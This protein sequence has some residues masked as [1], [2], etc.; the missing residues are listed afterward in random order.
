MHLTMP[1]PERTLRVLTAAM[2]A[3]SAF[4]CH[5]DS[6]CEDCDPDPTSREVVLEVRGPGAIGATDVG[7]SCKFGCTSIEFRVALDSTL[8]LAALASCDGR[9]VRWEGDC[10]AAGAS[11]QVVVDRDIHC[12]AVF[13]HDAGAMPAAASTDTSLLF[14]HDEA[15]GWYVS[16]AQGSAGE[17]SA[18]VI[19]LWSMEL[20]ND[21]GSREHRDADDA[22]EAFCY[23][24]PSESA[25]ELAWL[26]VPGPDGDSF[27]VHV[28]A[29]ADENESRVRF[30]ANIEHQSSDDSAHGVGRFDVPRVAFADK[31]THSELLL[32]VG[33]GLRFVD[34]ATSAKRESDDRPFDAAYP[35]PQT[36]RMNAYANGQALA[37]AIVGVADEDPERF[38][39][40]RFVGGADG[41]GNVLLSVGRSPDA[42]FTPRDLQIGGTGTVEIIACTHSASCY[43]DVGHHYKKTVEAEGFLTRKPIID[44]TEAEQDALIIHGIGLTGEAGKVPDTGPDYDEY[45]TYLEETL[46]YLGVEPERFVSVWYDWHANEFDKSL[47]AHLPARG[48]FAGALTSALTDGH[49]ILPYTNPTMWNTS[50]PD[51]GPLDIAKSAGVVD[52]SGDLK[53]F[54]EADGEKATILDYGSEFPGAHFP[55]ALYGPLFAMGVGGIYMDYFPQVHRC[56]ADNHGHPVGGGDSLIRGTRRFWAALGS[57]AQSSTGRKIILN[58]AMGDYLVDHSVAANWYRELDLVN[59]GPNPNAGFVPIFDA[60]FRDRLAMTTVGPAD[61]P[62]LEVLTSARKAALDGDPTVANLLLDN[63]FMLAGWAISAGH[64]PVLI[65]RPIVDEV[66]GVETL[67]EDPVFGPMMTSYRASVALRKRP[68]LSKFLITG[69]LAAPPRNEEVPT[70]DS[71]LATHAVMPV[72]RNAVP[73]VF[74]NVFVSKNGDVAVSVFNWSNKP[75]H[76]KAVIDLRDYGAAATGASF[77]D[78]WKVVAHYEDGETLLGV[79][80]NANANLLVIDVDVPSREPFLLAYEKVP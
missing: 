76:Y 56:F 58:E 66:N 23:L 64:V 39:I 27:A 80:V 65:R 33:G 77:D 34:P 19:S 28:R 63:Y 12:T 75:E 46:D 74:A 45:R 71:P 11:A 5:E 48:D 50:L 37:A 59:A 29:Y 2:V 55:D 49:R 67:R 43:V 35:L 24:D 40:K 53:T 8:E 38:A 62:G 69:S 20:W 41:S 51:Y 68:A 54:N 13:E 36:M 1:H 6:T 3:I 44:A 25:V 30:R 73:K 10:S 7:E 26:G 18:A 31:G 72:A 52:A 17:F 79:D 47:P 42:P 14:E 70:I 4:A 21:S 57:L 78:L 32:G 60:A 16:S 22:A 9:F 61:M 15:V